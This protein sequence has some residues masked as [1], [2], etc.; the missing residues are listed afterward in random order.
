MI[1]VDVVEV[2]GEPLNGLRY[3]LIPRTVIN[4]R[5]QVVHSGWV[6]FGFGLLSK[7]RSIQQ[8]VGDVSEFVILYRDFEA[9]SEYGDIHWQCWSINGV[10]KAAYAR[11]DPNLGN[12][13][14]RNTKKKAA[15]MDEE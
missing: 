7:N 13:S 9:I 15:L 4:S 14:L 8:D 12:V 3:A 10:V 1:I 6:G 11:D 2:N 5:V